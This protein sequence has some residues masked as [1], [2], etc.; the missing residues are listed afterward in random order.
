MKEKISGFFMILWALNVAGFLLSLPLTI[1]LQTIKYL[2]FGV[3]EAFSGLALL[4]KLN[5]KSDWIESPNDWVGL[6][7]LLDWVN[8]G[9]LLMFIFFVATLINKFLVD[10]FSKK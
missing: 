7:M 2:K 3:W 4:K 10:D 8:G 6:H 9:V 5:F 1:G